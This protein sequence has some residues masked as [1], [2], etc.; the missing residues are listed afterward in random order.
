MGQPQVGALMNPNG[1]LE[2]SGRIV[3]SLHDAARMEA[4]CSNTVWQSCGLPGWTAEYM[5][6]AVCLQTQDVAGL[7]H[8]RFGSR[9]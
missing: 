8:R 5:G 6:E 9:L 2:V 4:P 1:S 7:M 3:A